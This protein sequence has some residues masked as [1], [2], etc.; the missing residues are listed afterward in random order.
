MYINSRRRTERK[1]KKRVIFLLLLRSRIY[2]QTSYAVSST[3]FPLIYSVDVVMR[4]NNNSDEMMRFA[5]GC[6]RVN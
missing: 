3:F 4:N 5:C 2:K 1:I 6:E